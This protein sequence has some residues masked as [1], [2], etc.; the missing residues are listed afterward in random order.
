MAKQSRNTLKSYFETG[1]RP[2]EGQFSNLLDSTLLL[3]GNNTG[4]LKLDGTITISNNGNIEGV[5]QFQSV[6]A[7]G[8][9][10]LTVGTNIT[11]SGN[12]SS[13]GTITANSYIGLPSGLISSSAQFNSI[14]TGQGATEVYLMN[15]NE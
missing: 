9:S 5:D 4:S 8:L 14:D 10:S 7:V 6:D 1:K 2:T 11:A 3:D 12:I 13:S 15:Q